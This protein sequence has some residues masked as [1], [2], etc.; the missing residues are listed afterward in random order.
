MTGHSL[1]AAPPAEVASH[2]VGLS[3]ADRRTLA[4]VGYVVLAD[5]VDPASLAAMR[6]TFDEAWADGE[7]GITERLRLLGYPAFRE[8][9]D[10]ESL[11]AVPRS[12]F[13]GH[14]Q[15]LDCWLT[16]Q[17]P[18]SR[19]RTRKYTAGTERDWH[20]DFTFVGADPGRPLIVNMLLFL[21]DSEQAGPTVVLPGSHRQRSAVMSEH[22]TDPHP[23]EV[24]V[25]LR[26]GD[27]LL[28]NSHLVHSRGRNLSRAPRRA[29]AMMW[30]YWFVKPV[31]MH[32][33]L[34]PGALEGASE[35]RLRLLGVEPPTVDLY[36]FESF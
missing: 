13:G 29:V 17:P 23:D 31:D 3:E 26:A 7:T 28:F 20:R 9:V 2:V 10:Q 1:G 12:I 21:H 30:G 25:A 34:C 36:L 6:A 33:P 22:S 24:E 16:Y 19:W 11:Q 14:L 27:V 4:E 32:L 18:A 8:Y 35:D 5:L 15:L